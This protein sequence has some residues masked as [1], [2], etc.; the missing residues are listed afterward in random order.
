MISLLTQNKSKISALCE[1]FGMR[2]LE[3]FGSAV[4]GQFD[5]RTSDIDFIVDPGKYGLHVAE[6]YL[7]FLAAMEDLL[8]RKIDLVTQESISNPYFLQALDEQR[9]T[10]YEAGDSEAAA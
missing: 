7:D 4:N 3:V 9:V 10:I 8:Q 1:T 5:S 2:K 6:R